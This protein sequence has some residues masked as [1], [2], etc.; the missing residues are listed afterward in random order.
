MG[1]GRPLVLTAAFAMAACTSPLV[2]APTT[3]GLPSPSAVPSALSGDCD[4]LQRA[5]CQA[6]VAEAQSN[7]LFLKPGESVARWHARPITGS[8]WPGC[9]RP[10]V[11]VTFDI[12]P[13]GQVAV[14]IGQY[15][16]GQ[17]AVCTY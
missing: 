3:G 4:G 8:D 5:L 1:I 11:A 13:S 6:A 17:L 14:T 16:S 10:T 12:A 9:G 7:G 2:P 15:P